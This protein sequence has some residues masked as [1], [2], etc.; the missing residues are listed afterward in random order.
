MNEMQCSGAYPNL[1]CTVGPQNWDAPPTAAWSFTA[2]TPTDLVVQLRSG[3]VSA[4]DKA[5][6]HIAERAEVDGYQYP[7]DFGVDFWLEYDF[8]I[9][10]G[11]PVTSEWCVL[12]QL[13]PMNVQASPGWAHDF[14]GNVFRVIVRNNPD[15]PQILFE[16][17]KWVRGQWYHFL[18]HFRWGVNGCC[19]VWRDGVEIVKYAGALGYADTVGPYFKFGIYRDPSPETLIV[20]YKSLKIGPTSS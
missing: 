4:W 15:R 6:D 14:G 7:E 8:L 17:A 16:D 11:D 12:G 1:K 9:Q 5:H 10:P 18:E 20:Q 3:D 13:H 2:P 19:N